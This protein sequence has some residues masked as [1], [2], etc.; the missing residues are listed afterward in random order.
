MREH[1]TLPQP[2]GALPCFV[3]HINPQLLIRSLVLTALA[4]WPA[5]YVA[6]VLF[7]A[8]TFSG[9]TAAWAAMQAC[10]S[11]APLAC[12]LGG[13]MTALAALVGKPRTWRDLPPLVTLPALASLLASWAACAVVPLDWG[14]RWQTWPIPCVYGAAGGWA[15]GV[16]AGGI[17]E[18]LPDGRRRRSYGASKDADG[19]G[20]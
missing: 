14:E 17:M 7:G 16:A 15:V 19:H 10:Y 2:I 20:D 18:S 3:P 11:I 6:A 12:H 8:P 1:D 13:S 9:R 4:G 5:L